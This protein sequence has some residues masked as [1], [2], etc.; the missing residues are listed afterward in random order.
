M[1]G[2]LALVLLAAGCASGTSPD[3][4]TVRVDG[5]VVRGPIQPVC[6][7]SLVCDAPFSA[8]FAV[9]QNQRIVLLFHSDA[10][11]RFRIQLAPG[12]YMVVPD[13]DA[14]IFQ[15]AQQAKTLMVP[16]AA[17]TAVEWSFD[18]GIR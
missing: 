12:L 7:V 2:S 5:H 15:P 8:G 3:L 13:A 17:P 16:N 14:P 18:T 6:Q 10:D 4:A 11:G 9:Y 1:V